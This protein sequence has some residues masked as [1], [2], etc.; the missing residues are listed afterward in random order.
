MPLPTVHVNFPS[1]EHRSQFVAARFAQYLG[2]SVLDVGCFEAPLRKLLPSTSYTGIDMAGNPDIR[3]DLESVDRLP[4]EDGSFGSVLC[5]DVLE[6]LENLHLMFN[7]VVR[8]SNRWVIISLPNCWRDARRPIARGKGRFRHYG[9]P[10]SKPE[11]RH[12]WFFSFAEARDFIL[13][14]ATALRLDIKEMF[15]T[16]KPKMGMIRLLRKVRYPGDRYQNRYSGTLWVVL[17]K[18]SGNGLFEQV[19]REEGGQGHNR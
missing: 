2:E 8:V 11:D 19:P 15:V 10:L 9:L 7:E 6:H 3:L 4:F 16:E 5:V 14:K 1:R 12:K 17:E 18:T 13:S